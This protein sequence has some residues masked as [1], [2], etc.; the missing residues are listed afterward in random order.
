VK[1]LLAASLL[2]LA[3]CSR[4]SPD[5]KIS[6]AWVRETVAGQSGTAAYVTIRNSGTIDDR[7]LSIGAPPPITATL[8]ET[9]TANGIS[10][11][12]P[13]DQGLTIPALEEVALKPGGGHVMISGLASPLHAG[14]A[15]KLTLRFQHSGEKVVDFRVAPAMG[16]MAH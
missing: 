16:G 4:G 1:A 15:M 3:S 11:M 13:L 10:S 7:L 12:R 6:D 8:H 5:I 2:L 14:D 9:S